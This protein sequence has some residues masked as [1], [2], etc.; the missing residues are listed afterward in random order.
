MHELGDLD[1][2]AVRP[3]CTSSRTRVEARGADLQ[4]GDADGVLIGHAERELARGL[5]EKAARAVAV[6]AA[7]RRRS[8]SGAAR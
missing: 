6:A 8:A 2:L 4:L 5:G 7:P 3:R 1:D